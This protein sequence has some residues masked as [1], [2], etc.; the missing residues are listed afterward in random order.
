MLLATAALAQ[1]T[2]DI[3]IENQGQTAKLEVALDEV[4]IKRPAEQPNGLLKMTA[5]AVLPGATVIEDRVSSVL[6]KLKDPLKR[7]DAATRG[8]IVTGSFPEAEVAPVLYVKGAARTRASRRIGTKKV[9][10]ILTDGRT[11]EQ[12]Q[13]MAGAAAVQRTRVNNVILLSFDNPYLAIERSQALQAQGVRATPMLRRYADKLA[14]PLDQF[15]NRQWHLLN[16]GQNSARVGIDVNVLPAWALTLGNGSTIAIVD[17]CLE[18]LHPDLKDNCPPISSKFHHDFNDEDDDPKPITANFDFHGT[19][20][21]GLAGASQN[22][23]VPDINTGALLGVSGV[24]PNSRLLG[25]R[26]IAGPFTDEDT[27]N[28][29]YWHPASA[30]VSVSNNSWGYANQ[31]PGELVGLDVLAKAALRDAAMLGRDG[32][33]QVTVFAA[34]NSRSLQSNSNFYT[35]SNSRFVVTVGAL[36]SFGT[37]SSYSTPGASLLVSAPGGGFGSFGIDQRCITTDVTGT[38]GLNPQGS[39]STNPDLGN[40]DYTNQMNGTSS[41]APITSGAVALMLSANPNLGWRD[42]KEILASTARRVDETNT[43]WQM[44]PVLPSPAREF[45]SANFKFS[46]DYGAGMVDAGAAVTRSLSWTNLGQELTQALRVSPTGVT[47][48][49]PDT[50]VVVP[51]NFDFSARPNLRAEQIEIEV[52]INHQFRGDLRIALISPAGTRSELALPRFPFATLNDRDYADIVLTDAGVLDARSGGWVF[53]TTH[54]W[55]ENTQGVWRLEV[56]DEIAADAGQL[57]FAEL[58]LIGTASG[59]ERVV[60]DQQRYTLTEPA[61]PANQDIV[62]RRLGPT[63]SSFTVDYATTQGSATPNV[64]FTPVSGTLTFAPGDVTKT[65]SVPVLPD[66]VPENVE[67]INIVL[68]NLQGPGVSFGGTT[69]TSIDII[70]DEAQ[71]VTVT[72]SDTRAAETHFDLPA[73]PGSFLISRSKVTDQPLTVFLA[74]SGTATP[75]TGTDDYATLPQQVVIPPFE[76][77]VVVP[78]Q[79]FDDALFEGTETVVLTLAPDAAYII[80]VPGTDTVNIVDNDRPKIQIA[81]LNNDRTASETATAPPPDTASFRITRDFVTDRA[82]TVFMQFTGTQVLGLNYILTY[83]DQNGVLRQVTDPL[84]SGIDIAPNQASV[85]VT[86]VPLDDDRY[87]ATK[88]ATIG[89]LP[90]DEYDFSFGFLTSIDINIIEDDPRLDSV[91][92]TVGI[93]GPKNNSRFGAPGDV[94]ITGR[95]SDNETDGIKRLSYRVNGGIW[96]DIV[97]LMLPAQTIDWTV[98]LTQ[99]DVQLGM[100]TFEIKSVDV[101]VNES[102]VAVLK[103]EYFQDRTLTTTVLGGGSVPAGFVPT[104]IREAGSTVVLSA[105]PGPGQVFD[106]WT[107]TPAGGMGADFLGRTIS[108]AMPD[109]DATLTATFIASPF[110]PQ[111]A[112]EYHGLIKAAAFAFE[113]SG[114]IRVN[115]GPTGTFTGQL[116]FAGK[117]HALKGEFSGSGRWKGRIERRKTS[118]IDLDLTI[119]LNPAG[120]LRITGTASTP[121]SVSGVTADRAVYSKTAPA[122]A[123]LV[124]SYTLFFPQTPGIGLPQGTGS[125]TMNID[126]AGKVT[127][128]GHLPDGVS[129]KQTV[130]LT[131]DGTWPLFLNLYKKRGIM[132]GQVAHA[133]LPGSDLSGSID[134]L[135]P[136]DPRSRFFPSGFPVNGLGLI[137]SEFTPASA[138]TRILA[139]LTND[140]PNADTRLDN[141]NLLTPIAQQITIDVSNDVA[142]SGANTNKL[143]ININTTNGAL[144]GSFMHPV[145]NRRVK[146]Y[147]VF[148]QKTNLGFGSFLGS[149]IKGAVLQT[150]TLTLTP[151]PPAP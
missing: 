116:I 96:T 72:A 147:G 106:K 105:N 19:C 9:Q 130:P 110:V 69:L 47:G 17:D 12:V 56:S 71:V 89:F 73:D 113:S 90:S 143:V 136:S 45:N 102:K 14:L 35:T 3:T 15:F 107:L 54:H 145:S 5:E 128:T 68:T 126:T 131:K 66:A 127:W 50:G 28:A 129:V 122:P 91:I 80:G 51:F 114:F 82:L 124:K 94:T 52:R 135:R 6:V 139:G 34:G 23:G 144:T 108:F 88:L 18:T 123:N 27:A 70:D 61:T 53:S 76:R 21:G 33:G 55:G 16:T 57:I 64:D 63:T 40:N 120:T 121:T 7:A 98:T 104:S 103:F 112:G 133:N 41:A 138:G 8:D 25:L 29:L 78:V 86:L 38:G 83:I 4:Q 134:W 79:V 36:N 141:G 42:V 62:V 118:A 32:K 37:F 75:G 59:P 44:R 77:A 146:L 81:V 10:V 87:Q 67:T 31:Y 95:A 101:A 111:I 13:A 92:P 58:R 74:A 49:I 150:G 109:A 132:L 65:I 85:D 99:A 26:L 100:N 60:F 48:F 148:F 46:N 22:N 137:G 151:I 30:Q 125:A 1:A 149:S 115:V 97:G 140:V 11:P 84:N 119:D 39:T 20:V 2:F 93:S 142:V 117:T 43:S 24:A